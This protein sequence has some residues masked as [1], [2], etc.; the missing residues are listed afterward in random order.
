MCHDFIL[1]HGFLKKQYASNEYL[2]YVEKH[3][4]QDNTYSD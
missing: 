1:V 4:L 2:S 3:F